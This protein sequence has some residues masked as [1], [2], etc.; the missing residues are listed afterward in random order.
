VIDALLHRATRRGLRRGLKTGNR[1]WLAIGT[2]AAAVQVARRLLRSEPEVVRRT[3]RP[4]ET[5]VITETP[6]GR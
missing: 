1:W 5:L 2:A 3:L 6:G 4:D